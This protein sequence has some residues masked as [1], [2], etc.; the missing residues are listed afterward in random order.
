MAVM[1][2]IVAVMDGI[3]AVMELSG[4]LLE[5]GRFGFARPLWI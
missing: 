4:A 5:W 3:V 2:G 1:D